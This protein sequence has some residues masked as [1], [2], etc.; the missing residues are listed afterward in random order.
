MA[1][2]HDEFRDAGVRIVALS[3][4]GREGA[5][6]MK[7]DED[8][9][10]P[11]LHDLACEEVRDRFGVYIEQGDD[12]EHLQ[13]AQFILDPEGVVRLASYSSGKV[14]RLEAREALEEIESAR[15]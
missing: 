13:P 1:E 11:V 15:S 14:G 3:A 2:H 9:E 6:K 12:R 10:F 5:K 7:D 4:D 8:L